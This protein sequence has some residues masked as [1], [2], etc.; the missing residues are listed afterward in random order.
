MKLH[1]YF[2]IRLSIL[3]LPI[4]SAASCTPTTSDETSGLLAQLDSLIAESGR[5]HMRHEARIDSLK[6]Q[7]EISAKRTCFRPE[8]CYE[9]TA[10]LIDCYFSYQS[11]SVLRYLNR[12]LELAR[13]LNDNDRMVRAVSTM[14]QN[15]SLNGR[16]F[17]ADRILAEVRDTL[18]LGPRARMAYY[19][20]Q[21]RKFR[22]LAVQAGADELPRLQAT[23]LARELYYA[24]QAAANSDQA[25][26]R[27]YY[28]TMAAV[29][30]GDF[31]RADRFCDSMLSVC[32]P[33]SHAYALAANRKAQLCQRAGCEEQALVW[34]V[35]SS[36]ADMSTAVRDY[37][38]L[39]AVSDILFRRGDIE[40]AMRY[41]RVAV[42]DAQF[43]NSKMR[44]W[45]DMAVLP[46]IEGAYHERN[47][48]LHQM[49][50]VL[51]LVIALL[52]VSAIV[53]GLYVLCQNRRLTA[54]QQTLHES[55]A[56]LNRQNIRIA[57]ADRIKETYIVG[58]LKI[59][60]NYI[61]ELA[62]SYSHVANMLR[63]DRITQLRREYAGHDI[64]NE[65][66]KSFYQLFDRMFLSLYP[67]FIRQF[68]ELLSEEARITTLHEGMLTTKLRIYA[69]IRL[70]V[71]D[72]VTIA[73]LLHCSARTVYNIRSQVR[74][75]AKTNAQFES[76]VQSIGMTEL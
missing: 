67:D 20:A 26:E 18:G 10:E 3:L 1:P 12:N 5:I 24:G 59:I 4:L 38:S 33:R 23:H 14:S 42:N 64:R 6:T 56:C 15:F 17:D 30:S 50:V 2:A 75:S 13:Q 22:E 39:S 34:Y 65:E 70:G 74:L 52:A 36:M 66:L 21:H 41:I 44:S 19:R 47:L 68:N 51:T 55:N 58:F 72:T 40:R 53:G 62:Y 28:C 45:N 49:Y 31:G 60:S 29:C 57:D 37:G 8:E 25:S 7:L 71:T 69:L 16:L 11:D 9:L 61:D 43:Y 73:A 27:Y 63:N 32:A 35:R 76:Q 48:R 54:V 46:Q